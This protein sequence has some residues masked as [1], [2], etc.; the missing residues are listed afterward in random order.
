VKL[1]A[2]LSPAVL[3]FIAAMVVWPAAASA[4]ITTFVAPP[5]KPEPAK[6]AIVAE[7]RVRS[8]SVARMTL[9]DMKAWVDSAAG[10]VTSATTDVDSTAAPVPPATEPRRPTTETTSFS[11]GAIAPDTASPL[12]FLVIAGSVCLLLGMVMLAGRRRT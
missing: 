11:N 8:D 7:Q 12:P 1:R 6:A 10:E 9:T 5:R 4:Q 3:S 2:L